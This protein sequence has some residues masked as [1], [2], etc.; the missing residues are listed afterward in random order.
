MVTV[1]APQQGGYGDVAML[2][3]PFPPPLNV[4]QTFT[5]FVMARNSYGMPMPVPFG[6]EYVSDD[7]SKVSVSKDPGNNLVLSALAATTAPVKVAA[8]INGAEKASI[9]VTVNP[10]PTGGTGSVTFLDIST[11][12]PST[13]NVG[14]SFHMIVMAKDQFGMQVP[15]GPGSILYSSSNTGAVS[16]FPDQANNGNLNA[17]GIGEAD[18]TATLT[19]NGTSV[20][21]TVHIIVV[22]P[23]GG[24][25]QAA[26][27]DVPFPPSLNV[28]QS[29]TLFVTA[30]DQFNKQVPATG[31][32]Y[33]SDQPGIV[34]VIADFAGNAILNALAPG[35]AKIKA[36]LGSLYKEI[37]VHVNQPTGSFG[38]IVSLFLSSMPP[39]FVGQQIVMPP[40]TAKDSA[41]TFVPPTGVKFDSSDTTKATVSVDQGGNAIIF[42]VAQGT[43]N[44][45]AFVDTASG[46]HIVSNPVQVTITSG[47]G[48]GGTLATLEI[49][50][51]PSLMTAGMFAPLMIKAK[52]SA[53][54]QVAIPAGITYN[55]SA[56]GIIEVV[57]DNTGLTS[58]KAVNPGSVT[59]SAVSGTI[60]SNILSIMVQPGTTGGQNIATLELQC[61]SFINVNEQVG[62]TVIAKDSLGNVYPVP[63]GIIITSNNL[64]V[65]EVVMDSFGKPMLKGKSTGSATI[66]AAFGSITSLPYNVVVQSGTQSPA[67]F[68]KGIFS[69]GQPIY[70]A[71][72]GAMI[73]VRTSFPGAQGT[74]A[75]VSYKI[76]GIPASFVIGALMSGSTD[77]T[78][79]VNVTIPPSGVSGL[80]SVVAVW[81]SVESVPAPF[82]VLP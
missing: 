72:A 36:S 46:K 52:D 5:V 14:E 12:P 82:T 53:G 41:G 21:K 81:K 26:F 70:S 61:P 17:I 38:E 68:I 45:T 78:Y 10:A 54:V 43:V 67:P 7:A 31:I 48:T 65:A 50:G 59:L 4:G 3:M 39:I 35:D 66:T 75:D 51:P 19:T 60:T 40:V 8:K 34:G 27:L 2:E 33:S 16:V 49:S 76:G 37:N 57:T 63:S 30:R 47:S 11:L 44:I 20:F 1:N 71:N 9:M 62:I 74:P 23:T 13:M 58:V 73:E 28:G 6:I 55:I 80:V 32:N 15:L 24:T 56:P 29:F 18:I 25:G 64:P 42:G 69:A 77:Q 22:Q 79:S